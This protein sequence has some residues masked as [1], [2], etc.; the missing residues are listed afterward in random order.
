MS[1]WYLLLKGASLQVATNKQM[2]VTTVINLLA[3]LIISAMLKLRCIKKKQERDKEF[4]P[5]VMQFKPMSQGFNQKT[6]VGA[7]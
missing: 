3:V 1:G 2:I 6:S 5:Y 7:K 4:N